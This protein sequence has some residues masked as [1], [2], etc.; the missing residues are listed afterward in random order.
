MSKRE[1]KA[2]EGGGGD[3]N[4]W[5]VT[6]S[7]LL[8]LML[9]FFVLLLTMASMDD[10]DLEEI[11]RPGLYPEESDATGSALPRNVEDVMEPTFSEA[12]REAVREL[13]SGSEHP[14][15]DALEEIFLDDVLRGR[16][17]LRRLPGALA[18]E[19]DGAVAFRPGSDEL[20]EG[21]RSLL[22]LIGEAVEPLGVQMNAE[23]FV[24]E[25]T[26][27]ADSDEAWDLAL[28]RADRAVRVLSEVVPAERL[29]MMGL[30]YA[31]GRDELTFSRRGDILRVSILTREPATPAGTI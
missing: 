10:K 7:D 13:E 20:D 21:S 5:M 31:A 8:M 25:G 18:V 12:M 15:L 2:A 11:R 9:T 4:A 16:A 26:F 17:W 3:A 27:A 1:R 23:A 22:R 29:R 19:I 30:G 14:A 24:S 6:F 28:R